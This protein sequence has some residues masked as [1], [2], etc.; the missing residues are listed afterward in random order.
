MLTAK[1]LAARLDFSI[2][3]IY[4]WTRARKLP[5]RRFGKRWRY[6]WEEVLHSGSSQR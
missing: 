2:N 3:T 6:C 4:R 1:Q 5:A